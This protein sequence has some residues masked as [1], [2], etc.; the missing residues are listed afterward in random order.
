VPG[1][2]GL[3][4]GLL[5]SPMLMFVHGFLLGGATMLIEILGQHFNNFLIFTYWQD[6]RPE[7]S[8]YGIVV[9][10]GHSQDAGHYYAY[11]KDSSGRWFCCDDASVSLVTNTKTVLDEKAYMLFYVRSSMGLKTSKEA[12]PSGGSIPL[13]LSTTETQLSK[14]SKIS[15]APTTNSSSVVSSNG[16]VSRVTTK[17]LVKYGS[18]SAVNGRQ[19]NSEYLGNGSHCKLV[20]SAN[21]KAVIE[22]HASTNGDCGSSG[23]S[24][25]DELSSA[26]TNCNGK[27]YGPELPQNLASSSAVDTKTAHHETVPPVALGTSNGSSTVP[28]LLQLTPNEPV[29]DN[30]VVTEKDAIDSG[31]T[32]SFVMVSKNYNRSLY[33]SDGFFPF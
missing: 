25:N 1:K 14:S 10:A 28:A 4:D 27:F 3:L 19:V 22:E 17:P 31:G 6:A 9:H 16:N 15:T 8:L 13:S 23:L 11:V 30:S 24:A 21:G 5:L 26:V 33:N 29:G 18:I 32:K 2:Q 12:L 7:Y 20:Q